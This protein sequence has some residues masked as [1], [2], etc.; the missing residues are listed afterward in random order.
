VV[1][2]AHPFIMNDEEVLQ[3]VLFFLKNG[4]FNR[5]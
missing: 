5:D 2:T 4:E 3:Q 1:H